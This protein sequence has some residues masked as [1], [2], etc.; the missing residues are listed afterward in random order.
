MI[1]KYLTSRNYIKFIHL[2][3]LTEILTDNFVS[4]NAALLHKKFNRTNYNKQT[5]ADKESDV[6]NNLP[7][8]DKEMRYFPI[9]K[10]YNRLVNYININQILFRNQYEFRKNHSMSLALIS[11]NDKISASFDANK[12]IVGI[13]LDLSKAFDTVDHAILIS[14]LEHYGI[15]G[16]PR[17][18]IQ[19]YLS[20]RFQ[21]GVAQRS[22]IGPLLFL[23]YI[24][25]IHNATEMGEFILF[26]DDSYQLVLFS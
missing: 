11:L 14:K 21:C 22:I 6:W 3:I 15:R 1:L 2:H 24:N 7:S 13:F 8:L 17:E 10:V 9:F 20:N 25:D 4:R 19:T 26:A 16:L 18:W 23:L 5:L 12:H